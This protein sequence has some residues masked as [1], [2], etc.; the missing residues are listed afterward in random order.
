MKKSILT[1]TIFGL[2]LIGSAAFAENY[3]GFQTNFNSSTIQELTV[4][5]TVTL[6]A[7]GTGMANF[8]V[9]CNY[10][11]WTCVAYGPGL[12][13]TS[14]GNHT[15]AL[16]VKAVAD[17]ASAPSTYD[18]LGAT[19]G[20]ATTIKTGNYSST[21]VDYDLYIKADPTGVSE[22]RAGYYGAYVNV[23]ITDSL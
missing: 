9:Q 12:V 20:A 11:N 14:Q 13:N 10:D 16:S 18:A 19:E 6:N 8:S 17:G 23:K 3:G 2:V 7:S 1:L 21:A 22:A 4:D 15:I 5:S